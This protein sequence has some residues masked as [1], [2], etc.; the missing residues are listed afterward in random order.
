LRPDP[1]ILAFD[2]SA[3]HCAA[4][5]LLGGKIVAARHEEMVKGQ[6][7]RLFGML[8]EVLAAGDI[9]W[10]ALDAIG[11]GTGPGNFT[12]IRIAVSAGRG[13]ALSLGIPAVGVTCLDAQA[14]GLGTPVVSSLNA[15]RGMVYAQVIGPHWGPARLMDPAQPELDISARAEVRCIGVQADVIAEHMAG[16]VV[17]AKMSLIEGLARIA[18]E[19]LHH[20]GDTPRPTPL[21]IR[22]ADAAPSSV[23]QPDILQ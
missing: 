11:V 12:G 4:A 6:A 5:L 3:A 16:R 20:G 22:P 17:A 19:A 23:Q 8:E 15:P 13:L 1:T 21:Y 9:G 7:E 18:A 10:S 2:T 14:F